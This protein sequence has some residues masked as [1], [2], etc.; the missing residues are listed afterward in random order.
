MLGRAEYLCCTGNSG[1]EN[2][3]LVYMVNWTKEDKSLGCGKGWAKGKLLDTIISNPQSV[4]CLQQ[5]WVS[6]AMMAQG[7]QMAGGINIET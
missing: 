7:H 4:L 5:E 3:Y 2:Q 1:M 6:Q